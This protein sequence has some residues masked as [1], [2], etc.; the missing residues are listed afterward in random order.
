MYAMIWGFAAVCGVTAVYGLT[1][2]V[3]NGQ[4]RR[5]GEGATSIFDDEEPVGR[6]TDTFPGSDES[7]RDDGRGDGATD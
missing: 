2:A 4:L 3:K 6:M 5:F 7:H 1:W